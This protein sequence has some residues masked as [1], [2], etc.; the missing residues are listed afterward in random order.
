MSVLTRTDQKRRSFA[1]CGLGN[2]QNFFNLLFQNG[3]AVV[4]T[5]VFRDHQHYSPSDVNEIE[6]AARDGKAEALITT[7]KD[8]VKLAG[9]EISLPCYVAEI[10]IELSEPLRLK[11]L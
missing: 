6:S 5:K 2:P 10:D 9:S 1:F 7:A 3:L 11:H 8:A 4:G